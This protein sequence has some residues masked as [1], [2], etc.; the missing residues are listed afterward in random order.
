MPARAP[1]LPQDQTPAGE[2]AA[3]GLKNVLGYQLAQATVVCSQVYLRE[4]GE[5][6]E[7]RPVEYTVLHLIAENPGCSPVRLAKALAVTKPN[8]TMWVERLVG[9]G[10]V[11]RRPSS[12]DKRSQELRATRAGSTLVHRASAALLAA[13]AR[14][15]G[16][17]SAAERAMLAELL[18]K[19]A[20]GA[21]R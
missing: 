21:E 17:L 7:L 4:V 18:H 10:L 6:H 16:H 20:R 9:R 8:I 2:L 3:V 12:S 14:A 5:P 1:L 13:E 19:L 15:L 11:Q